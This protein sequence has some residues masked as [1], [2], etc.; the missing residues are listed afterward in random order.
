MIPDEEPQRGG[1]GHNSRGIVEAALEE[2]QLAL[3][4]YEQRRDEFI[5]AA[6]KAVLHDRQAAADA[7]D[8]VKLAGMVWAKIEED[9][10]ARSNPYREA[11]NA[12]LGA[13]QD[14]WMPVDDAMH[15]L[16]EKIR[17]FFDDEE[18]K[19]DEQRA[20]QAAHEAQRRA[21]VGL[22]PAAGTP[23]VEPARTAPATAPA[24][25]KKMRGSYGAVLTKAAVKKLSITDMKAVPEFILN[26]PR[27]RDAVLAVA[28]DFTKHMSE[29][30][31]IQIDFETDISIR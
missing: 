27:V 4:P 29:I 22:P 2:Q 23:G 25:R 24:R 21:E 28:R 19:I 20:A 5:A 9:R 6:G 3:I 7:A 30:P 13:A 14:F 10:L 11:A 8:I 17:A 15:E 1:M 31:G 18:R 16:R 26:S 12:V